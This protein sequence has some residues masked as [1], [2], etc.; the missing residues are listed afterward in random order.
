MVF[1]IFTRFTC[2]L[3]QITFTA[4]AG[5]PVKLEPE[6]IPATPTVSNTQRNN[7]R[8]LV[9]TLKLQLK[10]PLLFAAHSAFVWCNCYCETVR[11][12]GAAKENPSD[13][14]SR[15]LLVEELNTIPEVILS[16]HGFL[17]FTWT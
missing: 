11:S 12:Y 10:V 8:L 9:K 13:T 3:W 6:S 16:V 4:K 14:R 5:Q 2:Y 1:R 7:S 17:R 15:V